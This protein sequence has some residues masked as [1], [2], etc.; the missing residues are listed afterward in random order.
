MDSDDISPTE[1]DHRLVVRRWWLLFGCALL[2][3]VLPRCDE[4][5]SNL[6]SPSTGAG[7]SL[8]VQRIDLGLP[9][10]AT[11][12]YVCTCSARDPRGERPATATEAREVTQ[13]AAEQFGAGYGMCGMAHEIF[14]VRADWE[15]SLALQ[16]GP[17]EWFVSMSWPHWIGNVLACL[18]VG[19]AI[20]ALFGGWR[21]WPPAERV[22]EELCPQCGYDLRGAVSA[23]CSECGTPIRRAARVSPPNVPEAR[24]RQ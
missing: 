2:V 14:S 7:L 3:S 1:S 20:W 21:H 23:R 22:L 9:L 16:S 8:T 10:L 12:F 15:F 17:T 13:V 19:T 24:V 11:R 6:T 5:T 4:H 18:L